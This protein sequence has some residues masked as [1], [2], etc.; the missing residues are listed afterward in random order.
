MDE[1]ALKDRL[2]DWATAYGGEQFQRLGYSSGE[3]IAAPVQASPSAAPSP[4]DEIERVVQCMEQSGRWRE[5]RVL[6]AEFFLAGLPEPERLHRLGRIGITIG[7]SAYYA[8]LASA[9]A[10]VGGAL[11]YRAAA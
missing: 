5:S 1:N 3:R 8:Y 4:A 10:F 7:R 9:K 11:A 6:R 2:R